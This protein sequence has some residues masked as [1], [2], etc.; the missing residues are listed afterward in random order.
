MLIGS[1]N[2]S[3]TNGPQRSVAWCT[4]RTLH[5]IFDAVETAFMER[6]LAKEM[7]CGKIEG[8]ATGLA[9]TRLEDYWLCGEGFEFLLFGSCLG[10]VA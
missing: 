9:A 2:L 10:F 3:L 6:V 8:T 1:V 7:H 5:I 4:N